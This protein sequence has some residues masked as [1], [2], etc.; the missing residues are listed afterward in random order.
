M[1]R[2]LFTLLVVVSVFSIAQADI[3]I[4]PQPADMEV[5]SGRFQLNAQTILIAPDESAKYLNATLAPATG[6]ALK[7]ASTAPDKNYIKLQLV[8]DSG[9][10]P[11]AYNLEV[12]DQ[13]VNITAA[14]TAGL[15]YG[16]QTLRQLLPSEIFASTQQ[17][18]TWMVP[19]VSIKD[20][21]R[22]AWRGQ[23]LDVGRHY[24]PVDFIK[25][26]LDLMALHKLN[27]FHWHLTEDQGWRI[28]IKKYP[29]LTEIS[30]WRKESLI[31]H[32][33]DK[34]HTYDGKRYGGF[35]TQDQVREIVKYAA[36]L[37]INVVPEIEMPGHSRAVLAAYPKLSCTGG[38]HEVATHQGVFEDVYCAGNDEVFTFLQNVLDEVIE[39]FPSQY[40]HIGGDECPKKRWEKCSRC[41]ARIKAE[42]LKDEHELQSWFIQRIDRYLTSKGRTIIGWDEILEGGL[43]PNAA[44][45]SWRGEKGGI[46][47]A[48][49]E[50]YVV[51]SPNTYCYF[52]YYQ[53]PKED[54]P[55]AIGGLLTLD[56]VYSY[57]PVP[58][59]LTADQ[60][61]YILGIQANLWTE[62]IGTPAYAEYMAYP[63]TCALAEIAWSVNTQKDYPAFQARLKNHLIR[64]KAM[65]VN[66]HPL[67]K[68]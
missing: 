37:H 18:T 28:E 1:L 61:K 30:A 51:M 67:D 10:A 49:Q 11:E 16:I 56:K 39:L 60:Q 64:L 48:Q 58:A 34:P 46:E 53:G 40:I 38:P 33:R 59:Q 36:A 5:G 65:K 66:Y 45:M 47:A 27:T 35:Y 41:Q 32:W 22:F 7:T 44:V 31:G 50:H 23:H 20:T 9:L 29:K 4:L 21:P 8:P 26:Y 17:N 43:S 6:F 68:E 19:A 24:M 25:R 55:L 63:R 12:T 57:E 62:Y 52:D 2:S 3:S 54:E 13:S 14:D 15:F 42:G